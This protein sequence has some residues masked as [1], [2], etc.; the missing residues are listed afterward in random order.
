MEVIKGKLV[1]VPTK[2]KKDDELQISFVTKKGMSITAK[3]VRSK[4]HQYLA[5][6]PLDKLDGIEVD[7]EIESGQPKRIRPVGKP[8][9][10]TQN[11]PSPRDNSGQ[12]SKEIPKK[13]NSEN[14]QL[15]TV[16]QS[17]SATQKAKTSNISG[18]FHNPY[19]FVPALPRNT[20]EVKNSELG[21]RIPSGH[22]SYQ[23]DLWSGKISVT[24]TTVTPLLIPDAANITQNEPLPVTDAANITENGQKHKTYDIRMVDGKPYLPPTSI[25]G[26]LRSAYEAVTNSRLSVFSN[27]NKRLFYRMSAGDGLSL[28]PARIEGDGIKLM[29][30]TTSDI[31]KWD[32]QRQRWRIPSNT[33]Y[34]AWLPRYRR[35]GNLNQNIIHGEH[36]N[37]WL[38]LYQKQKKGGS[39]TIFQYWL[40][41][42]IVPFSHSLGNQP[43]QGENY[44]SHISTGKMIKTHGYV[45]LTNRNIKNKHDERVFFSCN[46]SNYIQC[47]KS[48]SHLI[49]NWQYLISNYQEIHMDQGRCDDL[50]WSRHVIGG[51]TEQK[52]TNGTLCYAYV[53]M[54]E[55]GNLVVKRLYP[56]MISRAIFDLPPESLLSPDLNKQEK[57]I[58]KLKPAVK[59]EDLS[60]ADRV[61]GWVNQDGRGS[62]KGQLRISFVKCESDSPLKKFN[63]EPFE[64]GLP[65]AI[66]GQPKPEQIR[67]YVAKNVDGEPLTVQA[68]SEGYQKDKKQGLRGRKVYP[69]HQLPPEYWITD[70]GTIE[71]DD[72][73]R[74]YIRCDKKKDKQNRTI[75]AW[76]KP[77]VKF[78]FSIEV[79]NLSTVEL[80]ALIWLLSL[81]NDQYHR[82]GSAKP[83]GFGSVKLHIEDTDL[84]TGKQWQE[85]YS[86]LI[87]INKPEQAI[88]INNSKENFFKVVESVY[89]KSFQDVSFIAAFLQAAQGFNKPI[90]YP[91][92]T[93]APKPEGESFEWFVENENGRPGRN[94]RR[95]NLPS[96]TEDECLYLD[97]T[98]P[99]ETR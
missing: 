98:E 47:E 49:E 85:F 36:V 22:A 53:E 10:D 62:Y 1:V 66:L 90:H 13:V 19:N 20:N 38:E 25:K 92:I 27:H 78:S 71:V 30:G 70:S 43:A 7:L 51:K 96:L 3:I 68:K 16:H 94:P 42:E 11:Q 41:R 21:D 79:I 55:K 50:E 73:Y 56:V 87:T 8:W 99:K 14:S 15:K 74:E 75:N 31:P 2:N 6:Q 64:N 54:N 28:V 29:F 45:C 40:V 39:T 60:P 89:G 61:F 84:R 35:N 44:H 4:L 91:R 63:K 77:Q 83:L 80:G 72:R 88:I 59:L 95:L 82:L 57:D 24:L 97:P 17:S 32:S 34:A 67:F 86:S 58:R 37:V 48:F 23:D 76:I 69:H 52:L 26:M 46:N 12:V 5:S 9:N 18:N 65:L 93:K 81:R 33:M